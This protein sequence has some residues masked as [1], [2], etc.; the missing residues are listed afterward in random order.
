VARV[1]GRRRSP[2]DDVNGSGYAK[3]PDGAHL[4][5]SVMGSGPIDLFFAGGFTLSME[6]R[7]EE[8]HLAHVS[9]R[10]AAFSRLI[11][12]DARGIGASDP[13]DGGV[14]RT[15][16]QH[17]DDYLTVLDAVGSERAVLMMESGNVG[18][19]VEL[20]VTR[21]DR[22]QALVLVNTA[23]RY[24][25]SDD[26]LEGIPA[27]MLEGFLAEN[28]DPDAEWTIDGESGDV[29]LIVASLADD[30]RFREWWIRASRRGAS[31][32]TARALVG[33]NLRV[34][35]RRRLPEVTQPTLVLHTRHNGFVPPPLGRYLGEHIPGAK[36]VWLDCR[37]N[38]MMGLDADV[39]IDEIEE[40][41]TGRRSGSVER[42]LASVL[43][44]DIVD[45]TGRAAA[46]GDKEWRALL[47][48]HDAIV[49]GEIVRYGGREVNTTGDGFV[50]AFDSPTQAVRA[51][52]AM[53]ASAGAS[54][55][56]IRVGIHTGE[57]EK[58]GEDLAGLTVHIAAR[59][60]SLAASGEVLVSRTVRDL[61]A[62]SGLRFVARGEHELKGVPDT[63]QLFALEG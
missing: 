7:D 51:G 13:L 5:Y 16:E 53:V 2:A 48:T 50:G 8:P 60:G 63:W 54:G 28:M 44:S 55:V 10:L 11:R 36:L 40:F 46:L 33:G 17:A 42:V 20:A 23:A 58:R 37:D 29:D 18:G 19:V 31:P 41:L 43:F 52:L 34:D 39:Y 45:S 26:Y 21:P 24:F 49:R 14:P 9:R 30:V 62:G 6:S 38:S 3:T 1:D 25:Q 22:V 27:E 12:F 47:D 35:A 56:A 4:A 59:V 32:A 61:V 57:V 15:P